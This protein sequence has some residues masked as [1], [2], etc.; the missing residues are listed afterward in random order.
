MVRG[1]EEGS[2][3]ALNTVPFC[4]LSALLISGLSRVASSASS[5]QQTSISDLSTG[6]RATESTQSIYSIG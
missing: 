3:E 2:K 1:T 4:Q 6:S 5:V